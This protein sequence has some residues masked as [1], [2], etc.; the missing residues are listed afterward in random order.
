MT[1]SIFS[2]MK[3]EKPLVHN[4]KATLSKR[5]AGRCSIATPRLG[6]T[7]KKAKWTQQSTRPEPQIPPYSAPQP[8]SPEQVEYELRRYRRQ[9]IRRAIKR[10]L[11]IL[12]HIGNF[13]TWDF[14]DELAV[15]GYLKQ[16]SPHRS[17]EDDDIIFY[18]DFQSALW[19]L[20]DRLR[21]A[22]AL[23]YVWDMTD[24]E[25]AHY[26]RCARR[27]ILRWADRIV[28]QLYD[29][30]RDYYLHGERELLDILACRF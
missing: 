20:D 18:I 14:L 16:H 17:T 25:I 2:G 21:V 23:R 28:D 27:T 1:R 30:L 12:V 10:Y 15:I 8:A 6:H 29:S 5:L 7:R 19:D 26:F 22:F 3:N 24:D 11:R 4:T 9:S 13:S